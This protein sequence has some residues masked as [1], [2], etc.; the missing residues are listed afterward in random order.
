MNSGGLDILICVW[1]I[2][3]HH[4]WF[5]DVYFTSTLLVGYSTSGGRLCFRM[6]QWWCMIWCIDAIWTG[7]YP[8]LFFFHRVFMWSTLYCTIVLR[9]VL[10]CTE[11]VFVSQCTKYGVKNSTE[12][13]CAL[14]ILRYSELHRLCK[15]TRLSYCSTVVSHCLF[16][17][18]V[19]LLH[20]RFI[21][22]CVCA[23]Y[24]YSDDWIMNSSMSWF[25]SLCCN[26]CVCVCMWE[27]V[28]VCVC[29]LLLRPFTPWIHGVLQYGQLNHGVVCRFIPTWYIVSTLRLGVKIQRLLCW[30][31]PLVTQIKGRRYTH[32][33]MT[34]V[35]SLHTYT[36]TVERSVLLYAV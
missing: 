14:H 1:L 12:V 20:R 33:I 22:L 34:Q 35:S 30:V 19:H 18:G 6:P 7:V 2:K 29:V 16:H 23:L 28:C 4:S 5:V 25:L 36:H 11:V 32:L 21:T 13:Y 17:N 31:H 27:S 3:N 15:W 26:I 10:Y 9:T 24:S 8:V